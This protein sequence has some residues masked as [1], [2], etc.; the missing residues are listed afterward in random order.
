MKKYIYILTAACLTL[1]SCNG[2]LTEL[3][4]G[5]STVDESFTVGENAIQITNGCYS[6]LMYEQNS[7]YYPEWFIGDIASDDALK[8]GGGLADGPAYYQLDNFKT[9]TD[10]V[11]VW[12]FYR[13]QF[14]GIQRCNFALK[15]IQGMEKDDVL[16]DK[17]RSRLLGEVYFLR[18]Y[19]YFRLVRA[20]GGVPKVDFWIENSDQWIQ[21]RASADAIWELIISDFQKAEEMLWKK[22]EYPAADLGRATQ[23]AAQA[24]L[25]KSYLYRH[26]YANAEIYGK[27]VIDSGE[28]DLVDDY[29]FQF[30]LEGE[31]G[32]ESIFEIQFNY[33]GYGDYGWGRSSGNFT[34]I[35]T[36]SRNP[37]YGNGWGFNHPTQN[38]YN[39][40][41][42]GDPR[43]DLT[44]YD[45]E[46]DV[47]NNPTA[48]LAASDELYLGNRY[49]NRKTIWINADGTF[50]KLA[51]Q[52]RCPLNRKEIRYAD[53]LLMYAEA[54]VKNGNT[55]QAEW[56]LEEVRA[57]ARAMSANPATMLPKFPN[58]GYTD[59]EKAIRHERRVELAM[60][61]HRWFDIVRWG[62][63]KEV[64]DAY[65]AS[66]S[67]EVRSEM[68]DFQKGKHELLPIPLREMDRNKWGQDQQNPGY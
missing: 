31:N 58:Y 61:G 12:D 28:Y 42:N 16:T 27:K 33:E 5:T 6:P 37:Q 65:K 67:I 11:F 39:E 41:E 57:R 2:W 24:M 14:L 66:E 10:N 55:G 51:H 3:A 45:P 44:I 19:Y 1:T 53:V 9:I 25:L 48:V 30:L 17:L 43:R 35:L 68:A 15:I 62:V 56:A 36:R 26:D 23:G 40:Y 59:L 38:L 54:C 60:E 47:V 64:M 8:G 20:F 13:G 34:G 46:A 63:A 22:G 29:F 32:K 18:G 52:S 7:T 49:L 21:P 50:T 4:P